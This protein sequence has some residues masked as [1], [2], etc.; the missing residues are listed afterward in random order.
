MRTT[1]LYLIISS[2]DREN[3]SRPVS[4]P[5]ARQSEGP[6]VGVTAVVPLWYSGHTTLTQSP[7]SATST[8]PVMTFG[9]GTGHQKVRDYRILPVNSLVRSKRVSVFSVGVGGHRELKVAVPMSR[10]NVPKLVTI[11]VL[12]DLS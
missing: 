3:R 7:T 1:N 6:F 12:E 8:G 9:P 11:L 4:G 2:V 5:W 10:K